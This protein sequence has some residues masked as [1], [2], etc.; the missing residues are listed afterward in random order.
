MRLPPAHLGS[1][2]GRSRASKYGWVCLEYE[3]ALQPVDLV[4]RHRGYRREDFRYR[5]LATGTDIAFIA[6]LWVRTC[7]TTRSPTS[8]PRSFAVPPVIMT[9]SSALTG[10]APSIC[11]ER[12]GRRSYRSQANTIALTVSSSAVSVALK[13]VRS[14]QAVV[15]A[16]SHPR[17]A[18]V[19]S[20]SSSTGWSRP[21][22]G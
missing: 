1:Y 14:V 19:T 15:L 12:R 3:E 8:T 17:R 7:N 4:Q 21:S 9:P 22:G 18:G 16:S 5:T 10:S 13:T 11:Q 2:L 20:M 6:P